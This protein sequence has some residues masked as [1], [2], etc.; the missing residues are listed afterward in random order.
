MGRHSKGDGSNPQIRSRLMLA[1]TKGQTTLTAEDASQTFSATPPNEALR[2]LV[3]R[4]YSRDPRGR[5]TRAVVPRSHMRSS[6][7]RHAAEGVER[8]AEKGSRGERAKILCASFLIPICGARGGHELRVVHES[9]DGGARLRSWIVEVLR[10]QECDD[11]HAGLSIGTTLCPK[12]G[13]KCWTRSSSSSTT[14]G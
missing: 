14:C 12:E 7:W 10:L 2:F 8:A 1:E 11:R 3:S 4:T 6:S 13:T 5:R 9:D